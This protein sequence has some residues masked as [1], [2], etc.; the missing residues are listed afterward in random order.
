M[1]WGRM[2]LNNRIQKLEMVVKL[3]VRTNDPGSVAQC[4]ITVGGINHSTDQT[5]PTIKYLHKVNHIIAL[6]PG[7]N[8][9][10]DE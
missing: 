2:S 8:I 4:W 7:L 10:W 3:L 9:L 5:Q 6:P 1:C